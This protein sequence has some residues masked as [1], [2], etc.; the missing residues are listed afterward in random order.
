MSDT[1]KTLTARADIGVVGMAVMGS[2]LARNLASREGD[3]VAVYSPERTRTLVAEHP[4]AG[5]VAAE[6]IEDFVA[7]LTR[8]RTAIVRPVG[9]TSR[10]SGRRGLRRG[11][12]RI[13]E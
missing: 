12:T 3:R 6:S 1:A 9:A 10:L 11:L 4:E 7:S 2:K 13:S 8:P 5:F